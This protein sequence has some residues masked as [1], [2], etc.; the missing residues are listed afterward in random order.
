MTSVNSVVAM[1]TDLNMQK[2]FIMFISF[3][4]AASMVAAQQV[5]GTAQTLAAASMVAAQ[6]VAGTAQTFAAASMVADTA[7]T[8]DAEPF[9]FNE[10]EDSAG[11]ERGCENRQARCDTHGFHSANHLSDLCLLQLR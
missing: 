4:A 1:I 2:V 9:Q 6:Q 10:G 8:V 3:L 7:Q 5:A 11:C